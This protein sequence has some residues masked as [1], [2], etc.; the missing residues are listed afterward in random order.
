MSL[1]I[2][3][4]FKNKIFCIASGLTATWRHQCKPWQDMMNDFAGV[5]LY[6]VWGSVS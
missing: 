4:D 6:T 5:V 3:L 2:A 1:K